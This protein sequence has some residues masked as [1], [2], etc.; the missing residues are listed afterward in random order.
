MALSEIRTA[1]ATTAQFLHIT[2]LHVDPL[3]I[4]TAGPNTNCHSRNSFYVKNPLPVYGIA[5]SGCDSPIRLIDETFKSLDLTNVDFILWTGDSSRH[6]RDNN[7]RKQ[8]LETYEHNRIAVELYTKYIPLN[9]IPVIPTI[10][11]WDVFPVSALACLEQG[12]PQLENLWSV[13]EPLFPHG[14]PETELAKSTFLKGGYFS[15]NV[16]DEF[17]QVLSLNSLSFF[18][19]NPLVSDCAKFNLLPYGE[20]PWDPL[21]VGDAQLIWMEGLLAEARRMGTKVVVQGHVSPMGNAV[22]LWKEECFEWYVYLAGE[23]SD[24]ILGHYFGHINRDLVHV[25]SQRHPLSNHDSDKPHKNK[26]K[27][28]HKRH[29]SLPTYP[30]PSAASTKPHQINPFRLTTLVPNIIKSFDLKNYKII[31]AMYTGSSIVPAYNPGYRIG[32]LTFSPLSLPSSATADKSP[33]NGWTVS[34]TSHKTMYVNINKANKLAAQNS[35]YE[36]EYLPSCDTQLDYGM[37]DLSGESIESWLGILQSAFPNSEKGTEGAKLL[38][39]YTKCIETSLG[40]AW[41]NVT[42]EPIDVSVGNGGDDGE[43]LD[44]G[45]VGIVFAVFAVWFFGLLVWGY[46]RRGRGG[47]MGCGEEEEGERRPLLG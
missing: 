44:K 47:Y 7:R 13:W 9:D 11:N 8:R 12:D 35:S 22:Q 16:L 5:D 1:N 36:L 14:H 26:K 19:E 32:T 20:R 27:K 2:D 25:I 34:L 10:G 46:W 31:D 3:Y 4:P 6:D 28:H 37:Q 29:D 40:V 17:V 15:R 39:R 23:Y 42:R 38:R 45:L 18:N 43:I 30:P 41:D 21:H 33:E 24:V